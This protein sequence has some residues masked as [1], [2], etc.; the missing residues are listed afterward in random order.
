[1]QIGQVV[2]KNERTKKVRNI[3]KKLVIK[4]RNE[5]NKKCSVK[6]ED[7]SNKSKKETTE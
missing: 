7:P 4:K 3:F 5:Q 2:R 1:M 6:K